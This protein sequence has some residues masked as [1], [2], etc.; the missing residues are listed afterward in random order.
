MPTSR[1]WTPD[2]IDTLKRMKAD[3]KSNAKIGKA[4][5]ISR[6][7]VRHKFIEI[8]SVDPDDDRPLGA[9]TPWSAEDEDILRKGYAANDPIPV[10]GSRLSVARTPVAVQK[11]ATSLGLRRPSP[12]ASAKTT[13]SASGKRPDQKVATRGARESASRTGAEPAGRTATVIV[14]A[15]RTTTAEP[16]EAGIRIMMLSGIPPF[17][18]ARLTDAGLAHVRKTYE[19][20]GWKDRKNASQLRIGARRRILAEA[21]SLVGGQVHLDDPEH[22][23]VMLALCAQETSRELAEIA[24][25]A[26]L[27]LAWVERV[28]ARLDLEGV[29]PVTDRDNSDLGPTDYERFAEICREEMRTLSRMFDIVPVAA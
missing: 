24:R 4:L 22:M 29:W 18:A 19:S 7:V 2:E 1:E 8:E 9:R 13:P 12:E 21:S 26:L 25:L 27:P 16:D 20:L 28:F 3:G 10:I 15:D 17:E 23:M 14:H 6:E 5:G 11:R